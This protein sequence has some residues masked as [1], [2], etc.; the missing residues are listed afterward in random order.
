[1]SFAGSWMNKSYLFLD[2]LFNKQK[3]LIIFTKTSKLSSTLA[4][5]WL[6][7]LTP[8]NSGC[9]IYLFLCFISICLAITEH[10]QSQDEGQRVLFFYSYNPYLGRSV[11]LIFRALTHFCHGCFSSS[12]LQRSLTAHQILPQNHLGM[13]KTSRETHD[14]GSIL[15]MEMEGTS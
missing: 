10:F 8:G 12:D 15:E 11:V 6:Q 2:H 13:T 1:M 5:K 7:H 14:D 9:R 3:Q 4:R